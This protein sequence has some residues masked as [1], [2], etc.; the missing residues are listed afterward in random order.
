[1]IASFSSKTLNMAEFV[2]TKEDVR[3]ALLT[4]FKSKKSARESHRLLVEA[5]GEHALSK[6]QC[7]EW[8]RRFKSGDF[9]LKDKHRPGPTKK[10]EDADLQ[11]LLDQ[12]DTV[13]QHQLAKAL[14]VSQQ[15][16]SDRL[17]KMGKIQMGATRVERSTEREAKKTLVKF[18]F[19]SR[20]IGINPDQKSIG[21]AEVSEFKAPQYAGYCGKKG[22][23]YYELLKP[24]ETGERYRQQMINLNHS[25]IEKRP[26]W[27]RRKVKPI[28]LHDNAR[29]HVQAHVAKPVQDTIK[30]LKWEV[31]P[32]PS[33]SPDLAPPDYHLFR[34]MAASLRGRHFVNF[35]DLKNWL[36]KWIRRHFLRTT[37]A[38]CPKT[39]KK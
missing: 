25:L 5:Y 6:S 14:Q 15:A 27:A 18:C 31:L 9:D 8:F 2:P 12:D 23:L 33:Y 20:I 1:M 22:V 39:G 35:E 29:P 24:G 37:S 19:K 11:A 3:N 38:N 26:E 13:T 34:S 21:L 17:K 7:E 16:I 4:F 10:F 30:A 28:M 36:D 32:H